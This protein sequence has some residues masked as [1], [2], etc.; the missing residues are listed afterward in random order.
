MIRLSI[1]AGQ[2]YPDDAK[3][4]K[5]SLKTMIDEKAAKE[6]ALGMIVPHAG[7]QYSGPVAAAVFSRIKFPDTFII[8]GPN[9]TGFG[10]PFSIS[11]EGLWNTPLGNVPIDSDL[12]KRLCSK[13]RYLREDY[14]AHRREHSIEVQLPFLQY[15]KKDFKFVPIVITGSNLETY[16]NIGKEIARTVKEYGKPVAIVASSDMTHYEPDDAARQKD[17]FAIQAMLKLDEEELVKRVEERNITMCGIA[18]AAVTIAAV[19][20]LGATDA[21]LVKYATSGDTTGDHSSVVGYA[22]MIFKQMSPLVKLAHRTIETYVQEH[23]VIDVP[24]DLT[25]EMKE[26]AGV[27]VSIHKH[28]DLRGCIGTFEPTTENVA[29]EVIHNAISSATRDPRFSPIT[30]SRIERPRNKR[31]CPYITGADR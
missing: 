30:P 4:L 10:K 8:L 7:Y 25:P 29:N 17:D 31:R 12:A 9:H 3:E 26:R 2:F 20:E 15:L 6:D 23:K 28:G 19:K 24:A 21:E 16:R 13:S 27:F 22:G 5:E 1:V 11:T 18:P 14:D